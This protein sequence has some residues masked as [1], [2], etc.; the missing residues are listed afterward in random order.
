MG[1]RFPDDVNSWTRWQRA[2]NRPR[3]I[4]SALLRQSGREVPGTLTVYGESARYLVVLDSHSPTSQTAL[5]TPLECQ[6][7][8]FAVLSVGS[9]PALSRHRPTT[10]RLTSLSSCPPELRNV[11][12]V[13]AVGHYMTLGKAANDWSRKLGARFIVVQHGLITPMMAPLPPDAHLLAWSEADA[14]FW[15]SGRAG[16]STVVGSQ[17]L[18]EAGTDRSTVPVDSSATPLYLGQLHGAEL[19]RR[20][21]ARAARAF[22]LQHGATYRPHPSE[23]DRLSRAQHRLWERRGIRIDRSGVPLREATGPVVGVFSTGVLEAAARGLPAWVDFPRP[24]DW[25]PEFW[26]RYDMRQF[27]TSP[28]PAPSLPTTEPAAA[29]AAILRSHL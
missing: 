4:R 1:L 23:I 11:V 2:Q 28:T 26:E 12:A 15:W 13:L 20:D 24:P 16:S 3:Q 21:L 19:P 27:G 25:L 10:T 14:D 9:P 8:S 22:C 6:D 29:I 18:W 17:L 7:E 5:L